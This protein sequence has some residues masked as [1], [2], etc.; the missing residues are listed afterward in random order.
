M[1][2]FSGSPMIGFIGMSSFSPVP[3]H[4]PDSCVK[5]TEYV[6]GNNGLVIIRPANYY[7]VEDSNQF[8]LFPSFP[9][10]DSVTDFLSNFFNGFLGRLDKKFTVIFS[11][12]PSEKIKAVINMGYLGFLIREFKTPIF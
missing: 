11:E 6:T 10:V 3:E 8:L 9:F 4:I 7:W 1:P 2:V 5:H 12:I